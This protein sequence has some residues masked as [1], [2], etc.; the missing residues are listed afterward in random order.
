MREKWWFVPLSVGIG[1]IVSTIWVLTI[2]YLGDKQK[3][4]VFSLFWDFVMMFVYYL[5]PVVWFGVKLDKWSV[6][7]IM[8]MV[9][10]LVVLKMRAT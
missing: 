8:L 10:G 6:G 7:G 5:L 1:T 9:L 2:R 4:Y 3:I